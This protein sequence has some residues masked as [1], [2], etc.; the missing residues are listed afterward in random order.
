MWQRQFARMKAKLERSSW[1]GKVDAKLMRDIR[2]RIADEGPL[3]THAFDTQNDNPKEMWARPPH[4]KALDLMWYAGALATCHRDGFIKYYDLAERI[5]PAELTAQTLSDEAQIN[6]LCTNALDRIGF[7]SLGEIR[8][9]WDACEVK[10][11]NEWAKRAA[12]DLVPVE[13]Q[14][15]DGNWVAATACPDIEDRIARLKPPTARLRILNPFDPAIRD[16]VRL[17]RLFGFEYTVEMFVPAPKRKWGYY[18]YPLLE[19]NRFVLR[20]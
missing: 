1:Y 16:R 4:K 14:G 8:K 2:Q 3:S 13:V 15:A 19:G 10:E 17:N 9:F 7:G 11:V 20:A 18:V 12:D 6:W 5:F